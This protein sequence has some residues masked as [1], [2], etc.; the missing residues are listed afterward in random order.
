MTIT[1]ATNIT[2]FSISAFVLKLW[3]HLTA[4]F[5]L[6]IGKAAFCNCSILEELADFKYKDLQQEDH[7]QQVDG[8][9]NWIQNWRF[10]I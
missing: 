7:A 8:Q 4:T 3:S 2:L 1:K 5:K 9:T 10:Q 6:V